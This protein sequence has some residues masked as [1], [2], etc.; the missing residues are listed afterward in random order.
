SLI[1]FHLQHTGTVARDLI[2]IAYAIA[3][4]AGALGNWLLGSLYD[5]IGLPLLIGAFLVGAGFTPLVFF[6]PPAIAFIGMGLWGLNKGAQDT[7]LTPAI[8][9]LIPAAQRS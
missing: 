9:P 3:M 4:A 1:A 7:L 8:A 6:G 2:P 5:R